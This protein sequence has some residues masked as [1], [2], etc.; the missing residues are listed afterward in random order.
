MEELTTT[1][2]KTRYICKPRYNTNEN[3]VIYICIILDVLCDK[4]FKTDKI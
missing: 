1:D 2:I 3:G 4:K